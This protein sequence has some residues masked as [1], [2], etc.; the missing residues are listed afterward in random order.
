MNH[1]H[2]KKDYLILYYCVG[3]LLEEKEK[4]GD[5]DGDGSWSGATRD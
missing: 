5:G 4:V 3:E 2:I 1:S